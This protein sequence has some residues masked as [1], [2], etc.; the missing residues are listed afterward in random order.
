MLFP[1]NAGVPVRAGV[2]SNRKQPLTSIVR[3]NRNR[4]TRNYRGF[5]FVAV[6]LL[7]V[8]AAVGQTAQGT[9]ATSA[10]STQ[11]GPAAQAAAKDLTFDVASV[12]PSAPLDG[13]AMQAA[14]QAGKMPRFGAY[15]EGLR[16]EYL[17]MQLKDLVADAYGVKAYQVSGPEALNGQRFDIVA[18]MPEGST[19]DLAPKMLRA[20]LEDRFKLKAQL[21]TEEHPVYALVAAKGGPKMKESAEKPVPI[22]PDAALKPG[23]MKVDTP[24][25]T[26]IIKQNPDGSSTANMGEKGSFKQRFDMQSRSIHMEGSDVTMGGLAEMLTQFT[27]AGPNSASGRQVVD[28]TELKGYYEVT[29]DISIAALMPPPPPPGGAGGGAGGASD[30]SDPG[31]GGGA[32]IVDSVQKMGLKMESRKAPVEQVVVESVEK[33]P[34]DN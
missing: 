31:G 10:S 4:R 14:M 29:L 6:F 7:T 16:A 25:G 27:M 8:A 3:L 30:A 1:K 24:M 15:V 28:A 19:K 11:A 33:E 23:E 21:K 22:D 20:L 17:Q 5:T 2:D 32:G 9:T 12:R 18:R 26:M 34:T 13:P